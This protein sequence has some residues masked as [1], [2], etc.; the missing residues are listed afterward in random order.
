MK[1]TKKVLSLALAGVVVFGSMGASFAAMPEMGQDTD[2]KVVEA[3]E[4][5]SAFGIVNGMDD[6]KYHEEMKVTREQFA[7]ILVEAL[8]LGNAA[9]AANGSTN[10]NDVESSRWSS[11]YINVAVGQGLIK[12]Y[13]D[14]TFKPAAEVSYAEA[15]TMLVR[16]LGYK[17]EFLTGSWPGNYVA[18]AADVKITDDVKF[19]SATGKADRGA[20]ALLVDNT[21][22]A[23]VVK[24]S[25]YED[26]NVKYY[27]S[28][29]TLLADKLEITEKKDL[30][31]VGNQT[32]DSNIDSDELR[33]VETKGDLDAVDLDMVKG[34][35]SDELMGLKVK[36]YVNDDNEVMFMQRDGNED[37]VVDAIKTVT[38]TGSGSSATTD[39]ELLEKDDTYKATGATTY[40]VGDSAN[41]LANN[42]VGKFVIEGDEVVFANLIKAETTMVV[43]SI[44]ADTK[45]I[46]GS[47]ETSEDETVN[48]KDD[49]DKFQIKNVDGKELTIED[50]KANDVVYVAKTTIEGDDVA[51]VTVVQN[52]TVEGKLTKVKSDKIEIDD[53]EYDLATGYATATFSVDKGEEIK[54]YNTNDTALEDADDA[55]ITA[56]KDMIGRVLYFST[57]VKS[58]S[59]DVYAVVTRVYTDKDRVK[60]YIPATD[61]EVTYTPETESDIA[62]LANGDFIKFSLNKDGEIADGEVTALKA[63]DNV[64]LKAEDLGKSSIKL[65]DDTVLSVSSD[66]ILIADEDTTAGISTDTDDISLVKWEDIKEDTVVANTEARLFK[67][68][69]DEI[70]AIIFLDNKIAS[71]TDSTEA[72]YIIE[73]WKKGA[74]T[75]VKV[76]LTNGEV[77]EYELDSNSTVTEENGYVVEVKSNGDL[78]A[79][80]ASA[81][82]TDEFTTV[83][84][85]VYDKDGDYIQLVS[86]G[87]YYRVNDDTVI[88]D[89]TD[90]KRLSNITKNSSIEM[91][92]EDGKEVKVIEIN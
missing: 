61:E 38:V 23:K 78:A 7:K 44:D 76:A 14:G 70:E 82:A 66:S 36:V 77:K 26:G 86:N 45:E 18:K 62:A 58:T 83:T 64:T 24:V 22:D 53:K 43:K 65:S 9:A 90:K 15:V 31:L 72:A 8:G 5:L 6:G 25:S 74:D 51:V 89:G 88:Y 41:T 30:R 32:L 28:D 37:V 20:V 92:V 12:G 13:P 33:F 42:L 68:D 16:G 87:T 50:I 3:V 47:V 73:T 79:A 2:K 91:I 60:V 10:F 67:N 71:A 40:V 46:K 55:T 52:N 85:T 29:E 54:V 48:L 84:G 59:D 1:N 17:D 57:D 56:V 80:S 34:V 81:D 63:A 11:G 69:K 19:A 27:E 49:F 35:N 75:Y 4:R 21:L 39:V